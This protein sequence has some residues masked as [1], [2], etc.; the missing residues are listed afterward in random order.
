MLVILVVVTMAICN[1]ICRFQS[2]Q[3]KCLHKI[4]ILN[5]SFHRVSTN[6]LLERLSLVKNYQ[7]MN[8]H[9][10]QE[11]L[12]QQMATDVLSNE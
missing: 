7:T 4:R 11:T 5:L 1:I 9:Y 2:N 8:T 12:S 10:R 3:K 6:E